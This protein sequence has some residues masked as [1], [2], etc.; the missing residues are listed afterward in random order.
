MLA[1]LAR[2]VGTAMLFTTGGGIVMAALVGVRGWTGR[3]LTQAESIGWAWLGDV[4]V[5]GD[6]DE[7][8]V[9]VVSVWGDQV[10]AAVVMRVVKSERRGWIRAWTTKLKYRAHGVGKAVLE[11]AVRVAVG[12]LGCTKV[13]F[14]EGHASEW[15]FIFIFFSG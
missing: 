2:H 4:D 12:G 7:R 11:E 13:E 8:N 1:L 14:D 6:G 15:F 3:Y 10:I 5:D 9:V